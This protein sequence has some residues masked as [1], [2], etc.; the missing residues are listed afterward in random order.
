M[1][2]SVSDVGNNIKRLITCTV[3]TV[4]CDHMVQSVLISINCV[5]KLKDEPQYVKQNGWGEGDCQ[6]GCSQSPK[7]IAP[8]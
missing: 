8:N 6:E 4:Y 5:T 1:A 2:A 7:D 3:Y